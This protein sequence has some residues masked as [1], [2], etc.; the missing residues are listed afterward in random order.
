VRH[1]GPSRRDLAFGI[2]GLG[3]LTSGLGAA[4]APAAFFE[5]RKLPLG[6]QLYTLGP[7]ARSD[8]AG[9][10]KQLAAIGYRT[11]EIAGYTGRTPQQVREAHDAAGLRCTSA[12][13]Q[14][15]AGTA[16][17]PGAGGD[18]ARLAEHMHII[19]VEDVI[20]P[21]FA[22]PLNTVPS[23]DLYK[24]RADFLNKCGA[25][26]KGAGLRVG[27]HNHSAEFAPLKGSDGRDTTG[28]E[29]MI[30]ETDPKLVNF[31]LDVGWCAAAGVD[32]IA[33]LK[34]HKP[35]FRL[36]HVKDV[37]PITNP[38]GTKAMASTEIGAGTIDWKTVLPAAYDVGVRKFF[39]EQE[40][41]FER[42]RIE[43]LRLS[44]AYLQ[45]V[46]V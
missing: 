17:E 39:V 24:Q 7:L 34:K 8:L 29:V 10:L 45:T 1:A 23:A 14:A 32:P 21:G 40:P 9:S 30:A 33:F 26:L 15:T 13:V 28:L 27:Y 11:T 38:N 35:R 20:V 31:Q 6:V 42:D 43:A 19:G 41:P 44:Y 16:E 36:A 2:A 3:A 18:L 4:A 12:H 46:T 22:T 37:K 5:R 25:G